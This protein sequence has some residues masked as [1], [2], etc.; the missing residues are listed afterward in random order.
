MARN[1]KVEPC[2]LCDALPCECAGIKPKSRPKANTA[3]RR[4]TTGPMATL[5]AQRNGDSRPGS[6]RDG[7]NATGLV[8][9]PIPVAS[10]VPSVNRTRHLRGIDDL[11]LEDCLRNLGPL[12]STDERAKHNMV[13]SSV[14]SPAEKAAVWKWR[15][16]HAT[17]E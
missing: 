1:S 7:P 9:T 8:S 11:V 12:L 4:R 13:L 6:D 17:A 2:M 16:A 3:E 10:V 15:K 5:E 14:P